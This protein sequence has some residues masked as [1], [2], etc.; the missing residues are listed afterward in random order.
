MSTDEMPEDPGLQERSLAALL[1]VLRPVPAAWREAAR[2]I[3]QGM[4]DAV[5]VPEAHARAPQD[6][7]PDATG[8]FDDWTA[9][10]D[11]RR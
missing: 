9:A 7:V 3:P 6:A 2:A 4:V 8:D 10:G 5:P 11:L 1:R